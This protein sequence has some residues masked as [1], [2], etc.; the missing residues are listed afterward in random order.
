MRARNTAIA[1]ALLVSVVGTNAWSQTKTGQF[2]VRASVNA[3]CTVTTRDLDFGVY[4]PSA[5]SRV[6]TTLDVKCTPGSA[7]TVSFDGG[8]SGNPQA[9]ILSG[10]GSGL[11]Y[12]LY[13]DNA[14][15]Q[16]INTAGAAFTL[17]SAANT[18]ATV[19][20][21]LYGQIASGQ[22]VAAGNYTDTVRVTLSY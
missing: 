7:V 1:A 19:T 6:N 20:Y 10:P 22:A 11:G 16:A 21:T 17:T 2:A 15:S 9:R 12:Q 18:G 13:K 14:Y 5:N 3:D 8:G 4:N